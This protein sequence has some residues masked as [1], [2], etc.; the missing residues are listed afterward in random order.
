MRFPERR[1]E[2]KMADDQKKPNPKKNKQTNKQTKQTNKAAASQQQQQKKTIDVES[3]DKIRAE[4]GR[5]WKNLRTHTHT[6]TNTHTN[7]HTH[8]PGKERAAADL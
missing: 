7:T 1:R 3:I 8:R 2:I 6:H 5:L 4:T